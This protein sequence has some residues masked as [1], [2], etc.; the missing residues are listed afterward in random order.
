MK[1][2]EF[3][4][5]GTHNLVLGIHK[6]FSMER[7]IVNVLGFAGHLLFHNHSACSGSTKEAINICKCKNTAMS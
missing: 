4:L 7:Q 6:V 1:I 2:I 3:Y 5:Q